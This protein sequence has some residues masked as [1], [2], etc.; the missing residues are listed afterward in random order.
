MTTGTHTYPLTGWGSDTA[1]HW[2]EGG[3]RFE[4]YYKDSLIGKKNFSIK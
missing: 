3:Y 2:K 4:F 1:G